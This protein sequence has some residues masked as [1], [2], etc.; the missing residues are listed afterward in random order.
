LNHAG[1]VGQKHEG[2]TDLLLLR[3]TPREMEIFEVLSQ[4]HSNCKIASKF[5]IY[6]NTVKFHLKNIYEKGQV[7]S[8][9]HAIA[10]FNKLF[11][12]EE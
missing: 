2:K 10:F 1:W 5:E 3:L 7:D 8:R 6:T 9:T 4:G 12:E 11:K